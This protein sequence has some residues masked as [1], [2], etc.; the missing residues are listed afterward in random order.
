MKKLDSA[1]RIY[2]LVLGV[3]LSLVLINNFFLLVIFSLTEKGR[4]KI[5]IFFS[6]SYHLIIPFSILTILVY[7]FSFF[8]FFRITY[9]KE[10]S[11]TKT[12]FIFTCLSFVLCYFLLYLPLWIM[13]MIRQINIIKSKT[14]ID[15]SEQMGVIPNL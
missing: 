7:I 10:K 4:E 3:I 5:N 8:L 13:L 9:L 6:T 14:E 1:I 15:K 12:L 11:Y 2:G